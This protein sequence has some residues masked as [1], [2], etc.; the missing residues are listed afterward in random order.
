MRIADYGKNLA[1]RRFP[2]SF[3]NYM[4]SYFV[5]LTKVGGIAIIDEG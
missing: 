1:F 5:F 3:D 4:Q 2:G